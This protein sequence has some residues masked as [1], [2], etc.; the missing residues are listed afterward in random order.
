MGKL[1]SISYKEGGF[2]I[3]MLLI[4][5]LFGSA[6]IINHGLPKIM[7]FA[8]RA[9]KFYDPFHIGHKWSLLLVIFAEV[10]CSFF[11]IIGLFT[12]IA[13]VPL[14]IAMAVAA[15]MANGGQPF[16]DQEA[17]LTFLIA[18][19]S[20]LIVGPGRFSVDGMIK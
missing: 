8:E 14:I 13:A 2:N 4:R 17:A 16:S 20:L 11:V 5:V 12:R 10:F 1:N 15:F 18:F 6:M 7:S 19:L 3:S 9:D